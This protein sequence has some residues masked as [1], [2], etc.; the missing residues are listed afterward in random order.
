[1]PPKVVWLPNCDQSIRCDCGEC[2]PFVDLNWLQEEVQ[3]KENDV[4]AF[5]NPSITIGQWDPSTGIAFMEVMNNLKKD[6]YPGRKEQEA[7]KKQERG[8]D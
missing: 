6:L 5:V 1:M 2:T 3:S 8:Q 4:R 7:G